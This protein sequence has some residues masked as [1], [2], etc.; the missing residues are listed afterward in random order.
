[1]PSTLGN[2]RK[3]RDQILPSGNLVVDVPLALCSVTGAACRSA[4]SPHDVD[5]PLSP[6]VFVAKLLLLP[7]GTIALVLAP[8]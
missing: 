8:S 2:P 5:N 3:G 4:Y 7:N 6:W 1:M